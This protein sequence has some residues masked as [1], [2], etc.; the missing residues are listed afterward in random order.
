VPQLLQLPHQLL[1]LRPLRRRGRQP[2]R[3]PQL[4]IH[5]AQGL[6]ILLQRIPQRA[7]PIITLH[8]SLR[9][10]GPPTVRVQPCCWW[11][12]CVRREGWTPLAGTCRAVSRSQ[13][14][15]E[16]QSSPSDAVT[17]AEALSRRRCNLRRGVRR[18]PRFCLSRAAR[19]RPL[20]GWHPLLEAP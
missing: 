11:G 9:I 1:L 7:P 4:L 19:R 14:P 8:H 3:R 17:L 5:R 10:P 16:V 13:E 20:A 6:H 2:E 12:G 18:L 15:V